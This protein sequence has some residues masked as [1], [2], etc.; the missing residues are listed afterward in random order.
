MQGRINSDNMEGCRDYRALLDKQKDSLERHMTDDWS[1]NVDFCREYASNLY[2]SMG[3]T[4][5]SG[6]KPGLEKIARLQTAVELRIK[7]EEKPLDFK[8]VYFIMTGEGDTDHM[9]FGLN[10]YILSSLMAV[11]QEEIRKGKR[12]FDLLSSPEVELTE[13]DR[14][15]LDN[16]RDLFYRAHQLAESMRENYIDAENHYGDADKA[17]GSLT[18]PSEEEIDESIEESVAMD[19]KVSNILHH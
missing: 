9:Y 19:L 18:I 6:K 11:N 8:D 14:M 5:R 13:D 15:F 17:L 10:N 12:R 2:V 1:A 3:N 4:F 16:Y 7:Q